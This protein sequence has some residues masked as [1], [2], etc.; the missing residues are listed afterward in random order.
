MVS[1]RGSLFVVS[2]PSGA[3]KTT[4]CKMLCEAL[5][6]IKHSVS[7]TTRPRRP[8]EV[9]HVDYSFVDEDRFREMVRKGEFLEWAE[10]HGNLYGTSRP[11]ILEAREKGVDV[12]MDIDTQGAGQLMGMEIEATFIFILP[13]SLEELRSRLEGRGTDAEEVIRRRFMKAREEMQEY[14]KYEYVIINDSIDRALDCLVSIVKAQR[15]RRTVLGGR[16][17]ENNLLGRM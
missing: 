17:I 13:P 15:C 10:V 3:G 9:D 8:G 7:Y 1:R 6:G 14:K 2:A 12:I 11:G 5:P 16:W 4:L